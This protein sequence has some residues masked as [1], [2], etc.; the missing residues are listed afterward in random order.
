MTTACLSAC[1]TLF[2]NAG[3][4]AQDLSN[5]HG[6]EDDEII[7]TGSPIAHPE[8]ESIIAASV[9]TEAELATR[10]EASIGELIRQEPGVSST[11]FG[12]AASRPIIRGLGGDRVSVLDA[13]IG[14]IDASTVSD[15][16][17][18]AV[19]PATA[20]RIEIVRGA[21]A[22]FFGSSAAGGVVN[23]FDGRIPSEVPEDGIDGALRTSYGTVNDSIEAAGGFDVLLGKFGDTALVFHGDGFYRKTDD[24]GIPGFAESEAL[25]AL[26][27]EEHEDHDDDDHDDHDDHDDEAHHDHEHEE[28]EA[29]GFVDNSDMVT[30][31]G[32]IGASL[33]FE[34]GFFGISGKTTKSNYGI[35]GGGHHHHEEDEHDDH[36]DDDHDEDHDEDHDDEHA[37]GEEDVRIALEQKRFDV[38]GELN[39]P[40]FFI[41][42]TKVRFGYAD[43]V[44][45]ELEGDEV[46]TEFNNTGY[47]ARVEFLEKRFGNFRGATGFQYKH[48]DF[49]AV[50]AEAF[51]PPNV[52]NQFG[53][54][55]VREYENG[56]VHV[57]V[58]G[59]YEHTS[60]EAESIALKR[61]FDAFSVSAGIGF[62][63]NENLFIG[64]NGL[65][66]ERAPAPEELFSDGP[67]LATNAYEV[68][69]PDLGI[70]TAT[71]IESTFHGE[72]GPLSVTVNGF[73][74]SYDDFVALIATG[75]EEDELP[76][77][78]FNARDAVFKGFETQIEADLFTVGG[79]DVSSSAQVDYVR[80]K[81]KDNGGNV[82]RIPP[83]RSILGI[84]ANSSYVDLRGE[85]ELA[86][87]QD[88]ISVEE[89]PTDGYA[90]VNLAMT[91]RPG[92]E[93]HGLS[94]QFRA[95][96]LTDEEAR[97]HTSFLKDVA[98]LPGR[99]FKV[100]LRGEF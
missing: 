85:V 88:K 30:K 48:R 34:D 17:A 76:V 74:T 49:E 70:E 4:Q 71:G 18:V 11:F 63:P 1:T 51:T 67:H 25:R 87:K 59:R 22:L 31:G 10:G 68:G 81:F 97:L 43:Y 96:N 57:Q 21:A 20:E 75:E 53:V 50:G 2:V 5:E 42:T 77:F 8:H 26:E 54:F 24:Y 28:E 95:D 86:A 62:E 3:G 27:E 35:P 29:F 64:V 15:D 65:R 98:S 38:R 7:V 69:D 80:A 82:P 44:H 61:T 9:L 45:R 56:P 66:T 91:W 60:T 23:V 94:V 89:L 55:T 12:P 79:F 92:G 36:D 32:S 19:E 14:S 72:L 84:E 100:T 73:Y 37:H 40:F 6:H 52:T 41:D 39:K 58:A 13:G 33:I 16:H 93:G 47:Q 78:E 99:N 46:G 83:L 90:L